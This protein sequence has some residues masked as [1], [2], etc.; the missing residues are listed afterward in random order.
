MGLLGQAWQL[1][2]GLG[3]GTWCEV[4]WHHEH[5]DST[6]RE[7]IENIEVMIVALRIAG[8]AMVLPASDTP[9]CL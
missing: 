4:G 3:A 8:N 2:G 1:A 6:S 9:S 7:N 5:D